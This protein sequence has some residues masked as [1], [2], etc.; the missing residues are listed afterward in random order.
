MKMASLVRVHWR[1]A[2]AASG[3][4]APAA[5]ADAADDAT[6]AA[7]AVATALPATPLS[8]KSAVAL[9]YTRLFTVPATP[10]G[11]P[12][13]AADVLRDVARQ[14]YDAEADLDQSVDSV[15]PDKR[16]RTIVA[17]HMVSV[18]AVAGATLLFDRSM[19]ARGPKH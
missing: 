15:D 4:S 18:E 19:R 8:P 17:A 11:K 12:L 9:P 13:T 1:V 14:R 5:A 6:D 16:I 10:N 3:W 7:A 2:V